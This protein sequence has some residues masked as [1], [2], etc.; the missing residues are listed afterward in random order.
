MDRDID[1]VMQLDQ[2]LSYY[3]KT[4]QWA[5]VSANN[6]FWYVTTR[7][8]SMIHIPNGQG[9]YVT[10]INPRLIEA[11]GPT[12]RF[13]ESC[14]SLPDG[15][16]A[17]KRKPYV[18]ISGVTPQNKHIEIAFGSVDVQ[19]RADYQLAWYG[20]KAWIAQH[21]LDHLEGITIAQKGEPFDLNRLMH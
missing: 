13:I 7:P 4:H 12:I 2:I 20:N 14:A 15:Y 3:R 21:E 18:A 5:G 8:L 6:I 17:V 9:V 16:Y 11:K 19:S 10:I 1:L